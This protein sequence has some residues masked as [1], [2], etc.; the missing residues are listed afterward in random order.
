M[1]APYGQDPAIYR[2]SH[3]RLQARLRCICQH[4]SVQDTQ[5]ESGASVGFIILCHKNTKLLNKSSGERK[6][7][8][9]GRLDGNRILEVL[10]MVYLHVLEIVVGALIQP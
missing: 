8:E 9:T 10:G 4:P 1:C 2:A 6:S 5:R 7:M 3:K